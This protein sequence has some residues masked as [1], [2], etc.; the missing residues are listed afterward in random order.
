ML[1]Q[2][3]LYLW[4]KRQL[5]TNG[6]SVDDMIMVFDREWYFKLIYWCLM[7]GNWYFKDIYLTCLWL[8]WCRA[9]NYIDNMLITLLSF[10]FWCSSVIIRFVMTYKSSCLRPATLL[11]KRFRHECFFMIFTKFLRTAYYIEHLRWLLWVLFINVAAFSFPMCW[12]L[13]SW[14]F[15]DTGWLLTWRRSPSLKKFLFFFLL[16]L[17]L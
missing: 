11:K 1:C 16:L 9:N 14:C 8:I 12:E 13:C 3:Q 17:F 4:L 2:W 6:W 7:I 5:R 10:G 15:T